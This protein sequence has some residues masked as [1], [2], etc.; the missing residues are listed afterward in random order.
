MNKEIISDAKKLVN[1]TIESDTRNMN[2]TER[3]AYDMGVNNAFC[4]IETLE[5]NELN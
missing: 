1:T 2:E 5:E 3:K 4:A